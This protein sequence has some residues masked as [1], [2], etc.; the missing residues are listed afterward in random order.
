[1]LA[2]WPAVEHFDSRF[3]AAARHVP[4][5]PAAGDHLQTGYRLWLV[6]HQLDHGRAPWLDPYTFRPESGRTVNFEGWPFGLPYWPLSAAFGPVLAWNLFLLLTYLAAG[7]LACA[8]LRELD[9]PRGAALAGGLVYAVAPYRVAQS[10]GH[11]LGPI[12]I[13]LPLALWSF[14]RARRGSEWWLV[15]SGAS[16]ASIPLSGQVHLALG[17]VPFVLLYALSRT[18]EPRLLAGAVGAALAAVGA[19]LLVQRLSISG[20][21]G[22]GGRTLAEVAHYSA[23][24]LD[25]VTRHRRHG[26]ESFV[27]LGWLTPLLALAGLALLMRT[28]RLGLALVLTVGALVPI[29]LALGTHL[30]LY[31]TLWHHIGPLRYPRVPERLLPIACLALAALAAVAVARLAAAFPRQA[32]ACYLVVVLVLALDLHVKVYDSARADPGNGAYAALRGRAPG[33]LLELPVIHPGIDLGSV[34]LYYDQQ[35]Q[36]QRPGGYSTVAP[37]KAALLALRLEPL[38]CGDWRPRTMELL[39]RLGVRYLALH[40]GLYARTGRA[41]FA[42]ESLVEH[43]YGN[44]ASDGAVTTFA[45]GQPRGAAHVPEPRRRLVFCQGWHG[46]APTHR[47]TAFW[48][49]GSRLRAALTTK[50]P[51]RTTFSVDGRR[52]LSVRVTGPTLVNLPLPRGSWHLVGVDI[53]RTDRGLR[54]RSIHVAD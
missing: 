32:T 19:G 51:D 25:F 43:G 47:H 30:P 8:W 46:L 40:A 42:W 29:L 41:W 26:L 2:T 9:L 17:A 34:Y 14:E 28:R 11:L 13:L 45:P 23:D 44:L 36:R 3:L 53:V 27:F 37:E 24:G 10:A 5:E 54:L 49:R 33:R 50:S 22:S 15:L 1:V 52:A 38:N 39:R 12:S 16:V 21:I 6:G 20:S 7:G 48:A 31:L 35:A 18:R 4:G